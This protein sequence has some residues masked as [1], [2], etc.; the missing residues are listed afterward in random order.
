M[1]TRSLAIAD[2]P[3]DDYAHQWY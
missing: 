1:K 3:H 2:K